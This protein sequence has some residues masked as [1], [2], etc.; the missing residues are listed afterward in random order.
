MSFAVGVSKP[1]QT[2]GVDREGG[3]GQASGRGGAC[4][5]VLPVVAD[6]VT[7][8]P[9]SRGHE[10]VFLSL[11]PLLLCHEAAGMSRFFTALVREKKR[12]NKSESI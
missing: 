3:R 4:R 9:P 7:G 6:D 11:F 10:H 8:R 12:A 5:R 2:G 1:L